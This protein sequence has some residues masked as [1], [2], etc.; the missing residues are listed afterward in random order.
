MKSIRRKSAAKVTRRPAADKFDEKRN[1]LATAALQT[2]SELGY[3]RTS[4]REIAKTSDYSH[5]VLHYYFADKYELIMF[6]VRQ[7][8]AVCVKRYDEVVAS[9]TSAVQLKTGFADAMAGTLVADATM[10]RLWYDLRTQS[11]FEASFHADVSEINRSL[12]RMIWRIVTEYARLAK[13]PV[14][15]TES[16][17]YAMFDGMFEQALRKQLAGD[18]D[19]A[20]DLAANVQRL[21]AQHVLA[22]R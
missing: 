9:A 17:A 18:K 4:L 10:H 15:V 1:E 16:F 2:L 14:G 12:E 5:G 11:M 20:K 3:A 6:C 21:L 7:Y 8:K 22:T 19:A 13:K